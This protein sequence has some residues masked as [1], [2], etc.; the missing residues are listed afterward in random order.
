VNAI[1]RGKVQGGGFANNT[2]M[3]SSETTDYDCSKGSSAGKADKVVLNLFRLLHPHAEALRYF[4][5]IVRPDWLL[6]PPAKK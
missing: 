1:G 3:R 2:A 4:T 6:S 5:A